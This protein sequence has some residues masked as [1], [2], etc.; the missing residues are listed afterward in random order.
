[1]N[2]QQ[3]EHEIKWLKE[4]IN[5]KPKM[6]AKQKK[7]YEYQIREKELKLAFNKDTINSSF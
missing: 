5:T 7:N 1:M 3:L 2:R 4:Q 6:S